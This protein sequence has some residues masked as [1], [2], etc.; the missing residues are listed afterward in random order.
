VNT[1]NATQAERLKNFR[2]SRNTSQLELEILADLA[3]GTVS[4]IENEKIN[5]TKETLFRIAIALSLN[6][7]EVIQLFM[8][9][10]YSINNI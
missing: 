7:D 3:V 10:Y 6:K 9:D 4:R 1:W 2:K 8:I 5:P